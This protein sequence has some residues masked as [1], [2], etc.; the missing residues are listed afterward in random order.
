MEPIISH[1]VGRAADEAVQL[2]A[3][4]S[5]QYPKQH[6]LILAVATASI[7]ETVSAFALMPAEHWKLYRKTRNSNWCSRAGNGLRNLM[8]RRSQISGTLSIE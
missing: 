1:S 2:W 8:E 5:A 7:I 6:N 3:L 4:A